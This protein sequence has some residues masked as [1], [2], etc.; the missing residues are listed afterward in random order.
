MRGVRQRGMKKYIVT[1]EK[2]K[3]RKKSA[4]RN[5]GFQKS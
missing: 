5:W 1:S 4:S 3:V 2:E